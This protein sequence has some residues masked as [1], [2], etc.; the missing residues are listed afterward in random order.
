[1]RLT[2]ISIRTLKAPKKGVVVYSDDAI[3]G[4]GVRV[5][6]AGTKS[7]VLT[8]GPRRERETI[9]RVGIVALSDARAEAKRRLAEYTLGK[10][11]A[12]A[13]A[14]NFALR[15]YLEHVA[16][17]RRSS[18]SA[19]YKRCLEK[20]FPFG[21]TK[22]SN[23]STRDIL[24]RLDR[25]EATPSEQQHA[26]ICLRA[27]INWAYRQHYLD[28]KPTERMRVSHRY[29]PRE[30]VLSDDELRRVWIAADAMGTFGAIVQLLILTGQRVGEITKL[31]HDMIGDDRITL[32][33]WLTKNGREHTFPLS[34][35]A[36]LVIS[37]R[38]QTGPNL[39]FPARG[40]PHAPFSGVSKSKGTLDKL[41]GVQNWTLHDLRRTF[42]SGMASLGVLLPVVEKLLNHISGSF[43]GIVAVYQRYDFAKEM[44]QAVELWDEHL[45]TLLAHW[46]ST[47]R[48]I[49][50][51]PATEVRDAAL[52]EEASQR[53]GFVFSG[54]H[55]PP[56][57]GR[58][59]P[60]TGTTRPRPGR[61]VGAGDYRL[62]H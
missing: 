59:V 60:Q 20:H 33:S 35:A 26:F 19:E 10:T 39:L 41:S 6:Q 61:V 27:F 40:K 13:V 32:P 54:P 11:R 38:R 46:A 44:R 25:L 34:S 4:F 43:S 56:G 47:Q 15:K 45:Q 51:L 1:M 21:A 57:E 12:P 18:T 14:W 55:R 50:M 58:Q 22:L 28:T 9:G 30:R 36:I 37:S 24:D 62:D 48:G 31:T 29:K 49:A 52:I 7:F 53:D 2:D 8:H 17:C 42:A 3:V 16:T 23:V 5:S